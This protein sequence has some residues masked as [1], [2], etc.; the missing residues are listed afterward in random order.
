MFGTA[1]D[2]DEARIGDGIENTSY[3][4]VDEFNGACASE[5]DFAAR[6]TAQKSRDVDVDF[7]RSGDERCT[8][9]IERRRRFASASAS[10]GKNALVFAIE[11]EENASLDGFGLERDG[12]RHAGFFVGCDDD[13]ESRVFDIGIFG[14]GKGE[15]D[16]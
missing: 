11:I 10:D 4:A 16:T 6:V 3:D 13:F 1:G 2:G 12:A 14:H 7:S 8:T 5:V 15:G 9:E